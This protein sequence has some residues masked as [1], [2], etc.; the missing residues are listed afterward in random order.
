MG[1]EEQPVLFPAGRS[2]RGDDVGE[3]RHADGYALDLECSPP[4]EHGFELE[5]GHHQGKVDVQAGTIRGTD[6]SAP[7]DDP[8]RQEEVSRPV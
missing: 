4:G 5:A 3:A 8:L 6:E 7:L 2:L 1:G